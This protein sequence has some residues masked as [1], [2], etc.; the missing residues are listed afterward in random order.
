[1]SAPTF[2]FGID[3]PGTNLVNP[4]PYFDGEVVRGAAGAALGATLAHAPEDSVNVWANY[5]LAQRFDVELGARYVAEQTRKASSTAARCRATA[6]WTMARYTLSQSL[7]LKINV[8]NFTDEY[9]FDQ[10]TP[11]TSFPR[12]GAPQRCSER[13]VLIA[14]CSR[15]RK[16]CPRKRWRPASRSSRR[17]RGPTGAAAP[18]IACKP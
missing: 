8:T 5:R 11:G 4:D 7:A 15:F 18:G 3:V 12:L 1:V 9:Y 2:A 17:R 14:C 10:V 13:R 6:R 16:C